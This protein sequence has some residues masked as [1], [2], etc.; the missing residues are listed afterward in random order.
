MKPDYDIE[1]NRLAKAVD[2]AIESF[3]LYPPKN[4]TKENLNHFIN[5]YSGWKNSILNPEPK[6]RKITSLKYHIQDVF[7]YF[8]EGSGDAVEHFW[9]ELAVQN[10][11]YVRED[12]L[13]KIIN[14]GIIK[15]RIEY[16]LVTDSIV[17]AQQVGRITE[18][19]ANQLSEM[20]GQFETKSK[21]KK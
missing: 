2:I 19:E 8:Q 1:A 4:F 9:K 12:K 18:Q 14:R 16:D 20:L 21:K 15:G 10:L 3:S 5:V 17:S 11:G 7:T 13:R 6:F